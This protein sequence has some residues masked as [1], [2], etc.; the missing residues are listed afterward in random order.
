MKRRRNLVNDDD[1][2]SDDDHEDAIRSEV[3]D[4]D[5]DCDH[6]R[7]CGRCYDWSWKCPHGVGLDTQD[8]DWEWECPDFTHWTKSLSNEIPVGRTAGKR[9]LTF[10]NNQPTKKLQL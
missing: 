5:C 9:K 4:A 7:I 3:I 1:M 8:I 2:A 10:T 6:Q